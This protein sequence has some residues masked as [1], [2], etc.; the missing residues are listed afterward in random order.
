MRNTT[1]QG[2]GRL[3]L[4]TRCNKI[5]RLFLI[6]VHELMEVFKNFINRKETT[7]IFIVEEYTLYFVIKK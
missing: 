6:N 2:R 4:Y 3:T 7:P 1:R 5:D